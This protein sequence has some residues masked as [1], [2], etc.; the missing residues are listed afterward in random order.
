[1]RLMKNDTYERVNITLPSRTLERMDHAAA[2]GGR[3]RLIDAAVTA[4]L[5][6]H[7]R[8]NVEKILKEGAL[9]RAKRDQE[10]AEDW[11]TLEDVWPGGKQ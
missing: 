9:T 8:T 6:I 1:M 5:N 11:L 3:S 10:L 2:R 7:A 4:Y